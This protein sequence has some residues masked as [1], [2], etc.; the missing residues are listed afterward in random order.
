MIDRY[1][2]EYAAEKYNV[3]GY[4]WWWNA[5]TIIADAVAAACNHML[6]SGTTEYTE[7]ER[8]ELAELGRIAGEYGATDIGW[9]DR[10]TGRYAELLTKWLI[11]LWD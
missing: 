5:D 8:A 3:E 4:L 2:N 7:G 11:R 9:A 6:V 1:L 10:D